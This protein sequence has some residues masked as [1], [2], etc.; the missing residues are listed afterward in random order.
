MIASNGLGDYSNVIIGT[1]AATAAGSVGASALVA[2]GAVGGPVGA[3]IAG[4]IALVATII[5]TIFKPDTDK[6]YSTEIVNKVEPYMKQNL[7]AWQSLPS[8]EKTLANQQ[9][10]L[11]NFNYLWQQVING[12]TGNY[13]SA[14]VACVSD[15]QRGGKWDWFSYYYDPIAN[16]PMVIANTSSSGGIISS[17]GST[18]MLLL[19]AGLIGM[20]FVIGGGD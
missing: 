8:N 19:G 10:A 6:I 20:A 14:G 2:T 15:R 3:A 13:G 1:Q 5:G 11:G 16:D 4:G 17:L 9:A 7:A 18:G 12:C